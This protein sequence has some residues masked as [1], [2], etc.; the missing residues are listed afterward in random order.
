[1][2]SAKECGNFPY[3]WKAVCYMEIDLNG[4]VEQVECNKIDIEKA[5]NK[6]KKGETKLYA[7]WPGD[8]ASDLFIMDDLDKLAD[9]YGIDRG[10]SHIHDI[11]WKI[12]SHDDKKS[13]YAY[14]DIEFKCGCEFD[15]GMIKK[16][17]LDL[18]KQ[19]GWEIATSTGLSGCAG[20][21][22]IK[23]LRSSIKDI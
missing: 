11:K 4:N 15:Y 21:Y 5:Y 23:V 13:R 20:K 17:A 6:A 1:M 14:V 8:Y 3:G 9:A 7:V 22:T 16:L 12:S 10:D 19:L 2:R 18:R